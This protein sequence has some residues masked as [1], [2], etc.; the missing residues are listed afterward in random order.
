MQP[1]VVINSQALKLILKRLCYELIEQHGDFSNTVLMGVQP[2]GS[3]LGERIQRELK[4][5]TGLKVPFGKLDITFFRD[6]FRRTEKLLLADATEI[7]FVIENKKVVLIDDVL[8]TGRTIR[9]AMDAMLVYGRPSAVEL[10][11]FVDRRFSRDLPIE[12][13]YVGKRVDSIA[14]QRV[15]VEWDKIE[16]EDK[17]L[18][19]ST[20]K[21][22]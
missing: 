19:F 14:S 3:E 22:K 15:A 2:R 18:M 21:E 16:G 8:Y 6:D 11:V 20:D 17:V 10:L 7:D 9:A 5:I 13:T 4:S 1:K 12:A